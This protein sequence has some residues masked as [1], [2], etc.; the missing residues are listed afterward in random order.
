M[1]V[2]EI[3]SKRGETAAGDDEVIEDGEQVG[4]SS[5]EDRVAAGEA[6]QEDEDD[7]TPQLTLPGTS[8]GLTTNVGGKKPQS[9]TFKI[10]SISLPLIGGE[11]KIGDRGW[12]AVEYEVTKVGNQAMKKGRET[13]TVVREHTAKPMAVELLDRPVED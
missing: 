13:T 11:L 8:S 7:G 1:G 12:V 6:E 4:A 10:A 3:G 9:A 2:T 5:I